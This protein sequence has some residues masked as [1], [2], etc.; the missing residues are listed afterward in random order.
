MIVH[1]M[2]G[3]ATCI[4]YLLSGLAA[5]L[6]VLCYCDLGA[7]Y[8][9]TGSAYVYTYFSVGELAA[10][11]TGFFLVGELIIQAPLLTLG[12]SDNLDMFLLGGVYQEW[13]TAHLPAWL[14]HTD[15]IALGIMVVFMV[16]NMVGIR[17]VSYLNICIA[18]ISVA[19]LLVFCVTALLRGDP[20]NLHSV[21]NP[22]DGRTGFAPYG[23]SGIIT[24]AGTSFFAFVGLESVVTLAEEA[25]D[26]KR[27]M[28]RATGLSFI[29]VLLLYVITAFSIA[30]FMPWYEISGT[31]GLISSLQSQDLPVAQYMVTA[32]LFFTVFSC[33]L[34]T[35]TTVVRVVY[36]IAEDGL[37][38][39]FLCSVNKATQIPIWNV[40]VCSVL[41]IGSSV[42]YDFETLSSMLS[43]GTLSV[44]VVTAIA[45]LILSYDLSD[46]PGDS[47]CTPL[48][49]DSSTRRQH[50][51]AIYLCVF[52]GPALVCTFLL[53]FLAQ[54]TGIIVTEVV[55]GLAMLL[56][57]FLIKCKI[58]L[59]EKEGELYF[60]SPG[61]PF[62]Q[63]ASVVINLILIFHLKVNALKQLALFGVIGL[64]VYFGYGMFFSK[65]TAR[66]QNHYV[67]PDSEDSVCSSVGESET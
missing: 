67:T 35:L 31:T 42:I 28:P 63:G 33:G 14:L 12:L 37:L 44:F 51:F 38:F 57:L 34:C 65:I 16:I 40:V 32:G 50:L 56:S 64:V 36:S 45:V 7:R 15:L 46:P 39:P 22:A 58:P 2:A 48:T 4:S 26:P 60:S 3:P 13:S 61:K 54:T 6:S 55:L 18:V 59:K 23:I 27:D 8:S 11:V 25:V 43:G 66:K 62:V 5:G 10:A 1:E 24:G 53:A 49:P 47:E 52:L 9:C 20:A 17:S 19:S 29:I 30:F 41:G 21:V